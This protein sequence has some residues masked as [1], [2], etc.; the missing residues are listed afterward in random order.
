MWE[1]EFK[2]GLRKFCGKQP[3]KNLL[4]PLLNTL[5][6]IE[7]SLLIF[8]LQR[9]SIDGWPDADNFG[10]KLNKGTSH[11]YSQYPL[12]FSCPLKLFQASYQPI[13]G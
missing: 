5:Y 2:N 4:S 10:F 3:L 11:T 7:A 6:H 9:K 8:N 1:K 13:F 12:P